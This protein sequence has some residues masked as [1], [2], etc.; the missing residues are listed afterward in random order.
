MPTPESRRPADVLDL[1]PSWAPARGPVPAE[2]RSLVPMAHVKS[3]ADSIDFYRKLGFVVRNTVTPPGSDLINWAWLDSG[4]AHLML[5]R[6]SAPVLREEQAILFYLYCDDVE[7]TRQA[8]VA[9]GI[10]ASEISRP[11]Y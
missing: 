8:L 9:E 4:S 6:A 2:I 7:A 10:L 5:A 3:V 1:R 11:F